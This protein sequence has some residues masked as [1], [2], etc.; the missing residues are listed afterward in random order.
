NPR[1]GTTKLITSGV[2]DIDAS[3]CLVRANGQLGAVDH[4]YAPIGWVASGVKRAIPAFGALYYE[5]DDGIHRLTITGGD[6][7]SLKTTTVEKDACHLS[8]LSGS[9][10]LQLLAFH[11]PCDEERL[12]VWDVETKATIPIDLP[13]DPH[14]LR[15]VEQHSA[16]GGGAPHPDLARDPYWAF[17]LT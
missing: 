17:Y 4:D 8:A 13:A 11:S 16:R 14:R 9:S 3:R 12:V 5:D 15:I 7:P 1:A 6:H 10:E 2:Q